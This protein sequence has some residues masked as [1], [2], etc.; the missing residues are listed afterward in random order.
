MSYLSKFSDLPFCITLIQISLMSICF[1]A[2]LPPSQNDQH[3]SGRL[4]FHFKLEQN[5]LPS[6]VPSALLWLHMR[7]GKNKELEGRYLHIEALGRRTVRGNTEV[8]DIK[9][10]RSQ[11]KK[12]KKSGSG[13][14]VVDV[15]D[16]VQHWFSKAAPAHFNDTHKPIYG[17]DISCRDCETKTS[18]LIS[19]RGPL[20]PFLVI[21]LDKPKALSRKKRQP[22]DCVG[23]QPQQECCRRML[24][25]N[26]KKIGWDWIIF[27]EGFH[28]NFCDGTCAGIV[29][30]FYSYP[31]LLQEVSRA[32][33]QERVSICCTP[34][35]MS[36]ISVLHFN[37]DER[38]MKIDVPDM[39][40]DA[41][42]CF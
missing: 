28:A 2:K 35:K 1:S 19:S 32:N 3:S 22:L 39:R 11:V 12:E 31:Y 27:P 29:D 37:N 36:A 25:V 6:S 16:I 14:I 17:L 40:V 42:G 5:S 4:R 20:R 15:K 21:D 13:W 34:T 26:F 7:K 41:C 38:V 8:Q 9:V 23:N 30:P 18:H 10:V 33:K 24:Y